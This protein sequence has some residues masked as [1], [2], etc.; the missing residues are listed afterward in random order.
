MLKL[1]EDIPVGAKFLYEIAVENPGWTVGVFLI[2]LLFALIIRFIK[3]KEKS[4][5][6]H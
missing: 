1:F 3:I 6:I 4:N 5:G 2:I